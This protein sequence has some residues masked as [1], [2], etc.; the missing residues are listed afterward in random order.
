[1]ITGDHKDTA[2]AIGKDLGIINDE[3][4]AIEGF[5]LD[6]YDDEQM[7]EVVYKYSVYARVQP[8][9]KTKI[10]NLFKSTLRQIKTRKPIPYIIIKTMPNY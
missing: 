7:K 4:Q 8:E 6:K 9:H 1:M 10:V 2:I 5:E 3:S